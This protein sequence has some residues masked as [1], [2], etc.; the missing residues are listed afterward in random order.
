MN[1]Y[2]WRKNNIDIPG[3]TASTYWALNAG[4]YRCL[5]EDIEGCAA[6]SNQLRVSIICFPLGPNHQK[7]SDP[8]DVNEINFSIFP[9][10]SD[11]SFT[12]NIET[13]TII[14]LET[15]LYDVTGRLVQQQTLIAGTQSVQMHQPK[16][17]YYIV[18]IHS[19]GNVSSRKPVIIH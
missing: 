11:G 8:S 6:T 13:E 2:Q 19:S 9:N 18:E 5:T 15:R 16:A 3:A 17:G 10:P 4:S 1:T 12:I 7:T 14:P